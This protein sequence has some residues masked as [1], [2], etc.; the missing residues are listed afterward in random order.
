MT[1]AEIFNALTEI[2]RDVFVRSDIVLEPHFMSKD[3]EGWDSYKQIE[4]VLAAEARF[5][6]KMTMREVDRLRT[7]GDLARII[8]AKTNGSGSQAAG[9]GA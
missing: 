5:D 9:S 7:V 6:I 4:I 8:A 2:F 3:V 1:E